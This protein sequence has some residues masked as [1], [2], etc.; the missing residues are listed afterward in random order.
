MWEPLHVLKQEM[1]WQ[2]ADKEQPSFTAKE[3]T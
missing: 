1:I 3:Y 2:P